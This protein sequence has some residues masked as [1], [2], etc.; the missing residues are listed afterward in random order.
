MS[1]KLQSSFHLLRGIIAVVS[2]LAAGHCWGQ[3]ADFELSYS[4]ENGDT[5]NGFF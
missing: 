3:E 5:I 4:G 1:Y 2:I